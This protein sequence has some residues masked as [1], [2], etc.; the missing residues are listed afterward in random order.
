MPMLASGEAA[1]ATRRGIV[2][3]GVEAH[4][5]TFLGSNRYLAAAA[6]P[7]PPGPEAVYPMAF[8]VEQP[9]GSI[10]AA[11]FH[12]ANQFQLVVAGDGMLGQHAVRPIAVHYANAF[13]AY[14][15][16][17][18]GPA[19]LQY[20]TLRNG[21][22]R[23]ARYL[24]AAREELRGIRRRFRQATADAAPPG[25]APAAAESE[26]LLAEAADGLGA[27]RHRLPPGAVLLGPDPAGGDGQFWVVTAGALQAAEGEALAALSCAFV[28]PEE[29]PFAVTAGPQGL[30]VVVM[31]YPRGRDHVPPA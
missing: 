31:Q 19:G 12:E 16:L 20:L 2:S 13:S 27:W 18:A 21:Y 3:N 22:D 28:A 5:T 14:G 11:H 26:V 8:L 6:A 10:V 29:A 1:R 30:E 25:P 15:P 17:A 24:P 4:L 23:G 9:P 7:P